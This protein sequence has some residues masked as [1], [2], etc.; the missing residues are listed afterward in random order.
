MVVLAHRP[1]SHISAFAA[2]AET[3]ENEVAEEELRKKIFTRVEAHH[4]QAVKKKI[5]SHRKEEAG[6]EERLRAFRTIVYNCFLWNM[7]RFQRGF[8]DMIVQTL[9]PLIVGEDWKVIG[10]S[11]MKEFKWSRVKQQTIC[12][13]PRRIG[14]TVLIG[15]A[16]AGAAMVIPGCNQGTFSTGKR[17]SGGLRDAVVKTFVASGYGEFIHSRGMNQETI[18][19]R[20]IFGNEEAFSKS[21]F[22][23]QNKT[24][25]T[26][27]IVSCVYCF[28]DGRGGTNGYRI[29]MR[30]FLKGESIMDHIVMSKFN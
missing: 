23:P 8:M 21:S 16:E 22:Y 30:S 9:A 29:C 25:S 18:L 27:Y 13:G 3:L 26:F 5:D 2:Y 17:A 28:C 14:K 1:V 24:I 10:P 20:C 11:I 7:Y 15:I 6:G 12:T 19:T 4:V